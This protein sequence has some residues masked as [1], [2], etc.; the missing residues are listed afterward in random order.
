MDGKSRWAYNIA[1][2]R[3][4]R[5]LKYE[6]VYLNNDAS[7]REARKQTGEFIYNYNFEGL[8]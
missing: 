4:F 6:E 2:E 1:I 3:W 8:H 5:T 7:T